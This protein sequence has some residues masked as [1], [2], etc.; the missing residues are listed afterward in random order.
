[1]DEGLNWV[2]PKGRGSLA[3]KCSQANKSK[4]A[5]KDC[6]EKQEN[7]VG[8]IIECSTPPKM[9]LKVESL[10]SYPPAFV[11]D[12]TRLVSLFDSSSSCELL[13]DCSQRSGGTSSGVGS[14]I[15]VQC[16]RSSSHLASLSRRSW[17]GRLR[18]LGGAGRLGVQTVL[19][20]HVY[21]YKYLHKN[22]IGAYPYTI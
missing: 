20:C 14:L 13:G 10:Q 17:F 8:I 2:S 19:S 9:H 12:D 1:V 4:S 11:G 7:L 16:L 6:P 18:F 3:Q 21:Q 5:T 15:H 22:F